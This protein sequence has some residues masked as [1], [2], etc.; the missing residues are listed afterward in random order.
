[1]WAGQFANP[2]LTDWFSF[3]YGLYF[4]LPMILATAI[5]LRDRAGDF[6]ELVTSVVLHMCIGFLCFVIFPAGP[7]RF[8]EPLV[9]GGFDPPVLHTTS[10]CSS[11]RRARSTPPIPVAPTARSRRCIARSA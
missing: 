1:M 9:H 5:S 10:G 3:T 2:L 8:Y 7:P 11:Y 4:I 6:R